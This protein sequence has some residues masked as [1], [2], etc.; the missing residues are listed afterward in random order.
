MLSQYRVHRLAPKNRRERPVTHRRKPGLS[1]SP[2]SMPRRIKSPLRSGNSFQV[3]VP[4][5]TPAI[6]AGLTW[7]E[8]RHCSLCR[9][10][11]DISLSGFTGEFDH[12]LQIPY[13]LGLPIRNSSNLLLCR[14]PFPSRAFRPLLFPSLSSLL[15]N[16]TRAPLAHFHRDTGIDTGSTSSNDLCTSFLRTY[17]NRI[18]PASRTSTFQ[19]PFLTSISEHGAIIVYVSGC[20]LD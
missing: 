7:Q 3:V 11:W 8:Y 17:G 19:E 5:T 18:R 10:Q 13:D 15:P 12:G 14:A 2:F 6:G 20:D 4:V 9:T 1:H 16:C